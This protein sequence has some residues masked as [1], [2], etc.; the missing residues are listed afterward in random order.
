VSLA[1]K[2]STV[3]YLS[4]G[5]FFFNLILQTLTLWGEIPRI[6]AMSLLFNSRRISTNSR[7]SA[8]VNVM[9]LSLRLAKKPG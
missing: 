7:I 1:K 2:S 8:S 6:L 9:P 5:S 4:E 3:Q